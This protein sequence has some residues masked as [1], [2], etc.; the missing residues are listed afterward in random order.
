MGRSS[1]GSARRHSI[2]RPD[3]GAV[4]VSRRRLEQLKLSVAEVAR[5]LLI[6][7]KTEFGPGAFTLEPIEREGARHADLQVGFY[8]NPGPGVQ[9]KANLQDRASVR[10]SKKGDHAVFARDPRL[11]G[12]VIDVHGTFLRPHSSLETHEVLPALLGRMINA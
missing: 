5:R 3:N 4:C 9:A 2:I 6:A 12:V 10:P 11:H 8:L 7:L 1:I